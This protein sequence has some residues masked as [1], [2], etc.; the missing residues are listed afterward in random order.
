[1]TDRFCWHTKARLFDAGR[2]IV[3]CPDA[4]PVVADKGE[5]LAQVIGLPAF[6]LGA[7]DE[8]APEPGPEPVFETLTSG[9][10]GV[11]RR[12]RRSQASW[13]ASFMVNAHFGIGPGA[14]VAVL[15]RLVH[16]LALYG[17]VEGL[18]LGAEVHL[19]HAL[20][21][22]RQL[23]ALEL[24][25]ISHLYATPAQLRLMGEGQGLLPD[26]RV[27]LVGGSKL[28][29]ALHRAMREIAPGAE[30]REFYGSAE[31]S[32]ITMADA[33]TPEGSVGRA[34]PGVEITLDKGEV[35]VKS[36]Y[37]FENYAGHPGSARWQGAWLSV[38]EM[39]DLRDGFL[40]LHGRAGRMVTIADQNVF[41]EEIEALIEA[42][43]GIWRAAVL[44]V[45]DPARGHVLVAVL[46]GDTAVEAHL[47]AALRSQLGPLKAPK[48]VI[49]RQ[50][51]P[52][53]PSGKTDL[54]ALE[55]A[56]TWPA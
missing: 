48:A 18:H 12:I 39:G 19:F 35:W 32:F 41:P 8:P 53:L 31:T 25:R 30:I 34:Y 2:E 4:V 20:R 1:M 10:S 33:A 40:F 46:Q 54:R 50:D 37:L 15:G 27:I 14:R 56:V 3:H 7:L 43:P 29:P 49:W 26:L 55:A 6:R 42:M 24:H 22:D 52:V 47:L 17:A 5:G 23:K 44:P 21:P 16:S 28:Q 45:P 11:A 9:S 51:W 38:G 13:I 36:P